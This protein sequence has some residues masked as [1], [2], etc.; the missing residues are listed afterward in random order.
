MREALAIFDRL[1]AQEGARL[2]ERDDAVKRATFRSSLALLGAALLGGLTLVVA[3]LTVRRET[4]LRTAAQGESAQS[5]ALLDNL[6]RNAPIGLAYLDHDLRLVRANDALLV[7]LTGASLAD[8]A[9]NTVAEVVPDLWPQLE[10]LCMRA[11]DGAETV[12]AAEVRGTISASPGDAREL[13]VSAYPVA[14]LAGRIAG[15]GLVVADVT[16]RKQAERAL[17]ESEERF[18]ATFEQAAVGMAHVALDGRILRV[19]GRF[20]EIVG[21]TR[22]DLR[23]LTFQA[24]THPEDLDADL[25]L[26]RQVLDGSLANYSLEKRYIRKEGGHVWVNLTVSL[27]GGPAAPQYFISVV[28]DIS[29]RRRAEEALRESESRFRQ[30][31][32]GLPLLVWTCRPDGA[33]DYLSP[34]WVG[35]TGIP[36]AEQLGSAWLQQIHPDDRERLASAW[37][38][39]V[40]RGANFEIDFRIRG[41][42]GA[43]RWFKTRATPLRDGDG[44]VVKWFGTN[45]D[46]EARTRAEQALRDRTRELTRSNADLEQFAYVASH[47]LQEPLRVVA[48]YVQLLERRYADRLD[49]DAKDF[50]GFAVEASKRMQR[51]INDLLDYSRVTSRGRPARPAAA[52]D[53]LAQAIVNL[54]STIEDTAALVTHEPLPTVLADEGQLVRLF[55]NL[56]AN[57]LKFRRVDAPVRVHVAATR[58]GGS[59]RF[60]VGDNGIGIAPEYTDRIFGLF[61]RLHA[62]LEYPGTGIGLALCKKIVERHGGRIWVESW[63]G[64]GS[65]FLFTLPGFEESAA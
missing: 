46:I 55:Q 61:Q 8:L 56:I 59:W 49:E 11:R 30:L 51:L 13:L 64:E 26:V 58:S 44:H 57:G 34:Q 24:I 39:T 31:A 25:A 42:D 5:L 10:P 6:M 9:G 38:A 60:S 65:T 27:V 33:C 12:A 14:R 62:P 17:R 45:T 16:E 53:A 29:E 43:H 19:N 15:V 47:D 63:P 7:A 23:E 28:E 54:R 3:F 4:N 18:R 20:A 52:E 36:E 35:Y 37:G 40:E 32:E 41:A 1:E 21:C 22:E 48:S 2:L 50:I